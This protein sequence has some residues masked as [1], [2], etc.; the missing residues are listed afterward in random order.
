MKHSL[1]GCTK[2]RWRTIVY[3]L[4]Y[5]FIIPAGAQTGAKNDL[6]DREEIIQITLTGNVAKALSERST[7]SLKYDGALT[8]KNDVNMGIVIPIQLQSR[9]NFR[10]SKD[11][12]KLPPLWIHFTKANSPVTSIFSEQKKMKLVIPCQGDEYIIR[13]W[14][15]YKIYNL[16]SP[17]SFRTR[18]VQ[19]SLDDPAIRKAPAPF[20]AILLEEEKQL[21]KRNK[22]I[23]V[24]TKTR[25]QQTQTN[26]F[27]TMTVFE[28]LIGNTDWSVQFLHNVKLLVK[29]SLSLPITVPYDFDHAGIVSALYALPEEALQLSSIKE[30]R[31]RGYCMTDLKVFEPVIARYNDLKS[32]IYSLYNNC[33]LIDAKYLK[34]VTGFLDEFYETIN[35]SKKWQKAFSYPCEPDGTG[36]IIIKGLKEN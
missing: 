23:A 19:V 34:F 36:N 6:F 18:L 21:A 13:E 31:Y 22:M 25:P 35:N 2:K 1:P 20:Y 30:R 16:I 3:L 17:L 32:D 11:N 27:L 10:R 8:Y 7:V 15:A 29:D 5:G 28:Y 24:E 9:G 4:L 12:C 14:L 26:P 33:K